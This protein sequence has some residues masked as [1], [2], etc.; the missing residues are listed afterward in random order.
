MQFFDALWDDYARMAPHAA[1]LRRALE[2]RGE[3]VV[4]DHVAFRTYGC[5]PLALEARE[6]ELLALGYRRHSPYEFPDKG[7]RAW[8]YVHDHGPRVFLSELVLDTL[9]SPA[10]ALV[11]RL[12]ASAEGASLRA[13]RPWPPVAIAEYRQLLAASEY[14]AWVAAFG[15]RANHFT[16]SVNALRGFPTLES[17]LDFVEAQGFRLNESGGRVKGSPEVLLEQGSTLADVVPVDFAD[18][19]LEIPS[20]YY[21]FARRYPGPDGSL[22]DGFVP[23]SASRIFESTDVG[24]RVGRPAG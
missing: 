12:C 2:D 13:G 15:L 19:V 6:P 5:G 18:G 11:E 24:G 4:N 10:R 22:Y 16:I 20:C 21:E 23:A 7:L 14:A 8:G 3:T 17:L 9:P 1:G